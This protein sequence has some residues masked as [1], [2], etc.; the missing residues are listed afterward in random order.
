MLWKAR[1]ILLT[2]F[3]RELLNVVT[4]PARLSSPGPAT[5]NVEKIEDR[6]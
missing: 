5:S 1:Y 2:Q 4:G 6:D 3:G